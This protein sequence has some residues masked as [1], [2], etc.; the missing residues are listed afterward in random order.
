MFSNLVKSAVFTVAVALLSI[1]PTFPALAIHPTCSSPAA[2]SDGDGYGW[3]NN[4]SCVVRTDRPVCRYA[5]SDPD[6]DGWG[7]EY[8]TSCLVTDASIASC[9]SADSDP[10]GDGWGWENAKS[11]RVSGTEVVTSAD[12]ESS[13]DDSSGSDTSDADSSDSDTTDADSSDGESSDSDASDGDSSDG[14]TSQD[15]P[16][17]GDMQDEEPADESTLSVDAIY[18]AWQG[19]CISSGDNYIQ[20][21]LAID[22]S[23][24]AEDVHQYSDSSCTGVPQGLYFPVRIYQY[25]IGNPVALGQAAWEVDTEITQISEN[26]VFRDGAAVGQQRYGLIGFDD[27]GQLNFTAGSLTAENRSTSFGSA[28]F[29]RK[30]SLS[31]EVGGIG[32]FV[33]LYQSN[34]ILRDDGGSSI[35]ITS[36]TET[37]S[38]LTDYLFLNDF[39]AGPVDVDLLTPESI[40]PEADSTQTFFG[41]NALNVYFSRD[42]QQVIAGSD[43]L[44]ED[45]EFLG[46]RERYGLYALVDGDTLM[47]GDC[48]LRESTCKTAREYFADMIDF[49]FNSSRRFKRVDAIS[50][51]LVGS[52]DTSAIAG[53][54]DLSDPDSG[55][56]G[57]QSNEA[58]GQGTYYEV[59]GGSPDSPDACLRAYPEIHT[60]YEGDIYKQEFN[61]ENPDAGY[62]FYSRS[63]VEE[64]MLVSEDPRTGSRFEYPAIEALPSLPD[65]V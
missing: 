47:R 65:C 8:N 33:G 22:D 49:E 19:A 50:Y 61:P 14:D 24:I 16:V 34:C 3:E 25:T 9:Q 51:P 18:G 10:D 4:A 40:V 15:D 62:V 26:G 48:V 37:T 59:E 53:L 17:N 41:D 21:I 30:P 64:E 58:T 54:W 55:F 5:E 12:G 7:W 20:T 29:M 56:Y 2:D 57:Y 1:L 38:N 27:L 13:T 11:C 52:D 31:A 63:F 23:I 36:V 46:P 44:T 42:T 43:L 39:C 6:G 28:G 35:Q 32:D 60:A 45:F